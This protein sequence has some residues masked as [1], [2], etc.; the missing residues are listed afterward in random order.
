MTERISLE[1]ELHVIR[2]G[3]GAVLALVDDLHGIAAGH[4]TADLA[5]S[6]RGILVLLDVR[7]RDLDRV[8]RGEVDPAVSWISHTA[9]PPQDNDDRDIVLEWTDRRRER[10]HKGE[11][12]R[13]QLQKR[14]RKGKRGRGA[15]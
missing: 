3:V 4:A 2:G 7:L 14:W 12:R 8:V 15:R 5:A 9:A 6:M 13:L 10:H 1:R 11:L